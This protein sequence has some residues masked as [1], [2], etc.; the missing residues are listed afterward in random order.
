MQECDLVTPEGKTSE[1]D[2]RV[3]QYCIDGTSL[4]TGG[5]DKASRVEVSSVGVCSSGP[6]KNR[7][8]FKFTSV[9]IS[10]FGEI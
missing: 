8:T 10:V 5:K 3:T 1:S 2:L 9:F 7:Q 4:L 6:N